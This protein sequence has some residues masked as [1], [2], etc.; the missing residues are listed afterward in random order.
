MQEL[1]PIFVVFCVCCAL[2]IVAWQARRHVDTF[3]K[4]TGPWIMNPP[5]ADDDTPR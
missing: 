1:A 3:K 4:K 2:L 5:P